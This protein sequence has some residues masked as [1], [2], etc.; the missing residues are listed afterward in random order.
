VDR[1][2]PPWHLT[3]YAAAVLAT[4]ALVPLLHDLAAPRPLDWAAAV[5]SIATGWAAARVARLAE[6][7]A[8]RRDARPRRGT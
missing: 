8:G 1:R 5:L 7:R 4:M 2:G 3:A 6:D